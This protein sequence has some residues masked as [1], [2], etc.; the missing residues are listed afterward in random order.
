[1][2]LLGHGI[3]SGGGQLPRV[4]YKTEEDASPPGKDYVDPAAEASIQ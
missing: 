3:V 1:M 2:G 4:R